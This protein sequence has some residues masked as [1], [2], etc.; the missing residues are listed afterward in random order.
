VG[1]W[2]LFCLAVKKEKTQPSGV[3]LIG[4]AVIISMKANGIHFSSFAA[5][6]IKT[7]AN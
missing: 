4:A 5:Y 2:L 7:A 3:G 1:R 6:L